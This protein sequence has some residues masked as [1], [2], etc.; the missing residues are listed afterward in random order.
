MSFYADAPAELLYAMPASGGAV[1]GTV[2]IGSAAGGPELGSTSLPMELPH[3]YFSKVG[4]SLLIEG[5]GFF[6][7]GSTAP[8]LKFGIGIDTSV[9]I[10]TANILC[11]TGAF[12]TVASVTDGV[13]NFRALVTATVLGTAGTL[14]AVGKLDWGSKTVTT[15]V[16]VPSY[17]MSPSAT[18]TPFTFNTIQTTPVYIEPFAYWSTTSTG[19]S[20]TMTNFFVWGLN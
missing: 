20:V 12:T 4:K 8:T 17:L 11:S 7:T 3:S 1:T 6:T 16:G 5:G 18:S 13:F 19:P 2:T 10:V 9:G 14:A 15:T